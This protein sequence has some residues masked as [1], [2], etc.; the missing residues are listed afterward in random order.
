MAGLDLNRMWKD[1]SKRLT[2]AIYHAKQMLRRLK[3]DRDV[4]LFCDLHGHSRKH[5]IFCYG[6]GPTADNRLAERI[7]PRMLAQAGQVFSFRD[8][9]FKVQR[10]KESTA[11]V[12]GFKELGIANS[13]TLEASFAGANFGAENGRHFTPKV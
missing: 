9:S 12:V 13:F 10:S 4:V 6:C 11:R 8:C 1:P 2:P 5:N 3:E 7:F